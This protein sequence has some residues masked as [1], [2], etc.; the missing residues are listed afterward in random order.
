MN[1]SFG[2][3]KGLRHEDFAILGQFC[4]KSLLSA[5]TRTQSAPVYEH[6]DNCRAFHMC[7]CYEIQ[8][9]FVLHHGKA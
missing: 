3:L 5:F 7:V 9:L 6:I 8:V 4:A 2:P 1:M